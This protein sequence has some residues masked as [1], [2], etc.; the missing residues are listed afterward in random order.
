[1]E[2][3]Q[4]KTVIGHSL[5]ASVGLE[6]DKN[7]NH[8]TSSKTYGAPMWDPPGKESNKVDCYRNWFDPFSMFDRSAVKSVK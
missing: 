6:L 4:V 2:N 3:P 1:M 5:G 8:I 7:C